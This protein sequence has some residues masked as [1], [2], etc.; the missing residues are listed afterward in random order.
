MRHQLVIP[1]VSIFLI[2]ACSSK[3]EEVQKP[4]AEQ[5]FEFEIY[6]SL[7][8]D[9]LGNLILMDISPD[10]N[11]F[12]LIDQNTD[13]MFVTDPKGEIKYQYKRTGEGPEMIQGNRTG[14]GQFLDNEKFL[15][16]SSRGV[17]IYSI[18]GEFM[19]SHIPEFTGIS[20]L[21]IP[22]SSAHA[23]YK[24][25]ILLRMPGRFADIK[26][27][28]IDFQQK[29]KQIEQLD[30]STGKF[31]SVVPFPKESKFSSKTEEFGVFDYFVD[32]EI[33]GDSLYLAFRNEPKLFVYNLS[34]LEVPAKTLEIGF[35]QFYERNTAAK[36]D[37][38]AINVRDF[39]LGTIN[40]IIPLEH[41]LILINYLSGLSDEDAKNVIDEAK[42]DFDLMFKN[43]EEINQGGLVLF[44][45]KEI[46]QLIS[47]PGYLGNINQ[48][49]SKDEIWFS[50]NFEEIENDY[51]VIYKTRLISN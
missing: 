41:D 7:V 31:E 46:S 23:I 22:S 5:Q 8:V 30:L 43:A 49:V 25:K 35:P 20:R 32:F 4:L 34:N 13:S 36:P 27:P 45:G 11:H 38:E 10:G 6:D 33:K 21:I 51:S 14:V 24:E 50:P 17:F 47:K 28:S 19:E 2:F 3:E 1:I 42:G 16:P 26:E 39:F 18:S 40:R 48:V 12:L 15:I 44:D 37:N 9:Y 29:S